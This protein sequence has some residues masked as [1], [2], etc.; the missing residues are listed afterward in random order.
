MLGDY[1]MKVS[2]RLKETS[3]PLEFVARNTYTKG[4]LYC[5]YQDSGM[6]RKIPLADI[7]DITEDYSHVPEESDQQRPKF[8]STK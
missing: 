7:F 5:I 2:V 1:F 8:G 3:Q 6:V 4:S